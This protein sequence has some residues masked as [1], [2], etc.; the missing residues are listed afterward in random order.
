MKKQAFTRGICLL[1]AIFLVLGATACTKQAVEPQEER[2]LCV[3]E[4]DVTYSEEFSVQA[5]RRVAEILARLLYAREGLVVPE[6]EKA[7]L[8]Q[9]AR[10]GY[11]PLLEKEKVRVEE[12]EQMLS[13]S[14]AFCGEWEGLLSSDISDARRARMLAFCSLYRDFVAVVGTS[15]AGRV[16]YGG[17]CFYLGEQVEYYEA[18]Y[19]AYGYAFY[20]KEAERA[21]WRKQSLEYEVGAAA[22]AEAMCVPAF[23]ASLASGALPVEA[24]GL[25]SLLYDGDIVAILQR[26]G[27]FFSSLSVSEYQWYVIGEVFAGFAPDGEGLLDSLLAV[28]RDD[29][30]L[31]KSAIGMPCTLALYAAFADSLDANSLAAIRDAENEE[32]RL[33]E[34][35]R[36]LVLCE[37]ELLALL[38][39]MEATCQMNNA[40]EREVIEDAELLDE[41]AAF[42]AAYPTLDRE[43]VIEAIS[44]CAAGQGG[45]D[46]LRT[47]YLRYLRSFAPYLAFAVYADGQ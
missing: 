29:G 40:R 5:S 4:T 45:I 46:M 14:E 20:K 22:F 32:A 9:K 44:A 18:R 6:E 12:L 23:A 41:L 43:G 31:G 3:E 36:V 13:R 39:K 19:E 2:R 28:W 17:L 47:S 24:A 42:E 34:L 7:E 21:A 35:C 15:R 27:R 16:T 26:Q 11:L 38:E 37:D 10:N 1:L 25:S 33:G 8:A 30:M